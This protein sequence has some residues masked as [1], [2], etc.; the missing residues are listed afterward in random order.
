MI[1]L[2]LIFIICPLL[3][4]DRAAAQTGTY[5][6]EALN[7]EAI[8]LTDFTGVAGFRN[9]PTLKLILTNPGDQPL[10]L[11]LAAGD[12][13]TPTNQPTAENQSY[14]TI[15]L[16]GTQ[17]ID[18]NNRSQ[19][20][21]V[22]AGAVDYPVE[23]DAYCLEFFEEP[24]GRFPDENS[25]Y[26][27]PSDIQVRDSAL[28][29]ILDNRI[30]IAT[31]Q[32]D[33]D[34]PNWD[35]FSVQ[36]AIWQVANGLTFDE[37]AA[38][39]GL[40]QTEQF[41]ASVDTLI[42]GTFAPNP[43]PLPTPTT[44]SNAVAEIETVLPEETL[45]PADEGGFVLPVSDLSSIQLIV[46]SSLIG[47]FLAFA[48]FR[49]MRGQSQP[50]PRNQN[51]GRNRPREE[52]GTRRQENEERERRPEEEH[53]EKCL[54]C[55]GNHET[56]QCPYIR[57]RTTFEERRKHATI[58]PEEEIDQPPPPRPEPDHTRERNQRNQRGRP[59]N[60]SH[61]S[62]QRRQEENYRA[63]QDHQGAGHRTDPVPGDEPERERP[64]EG[65]R[66]SEPNISFT[67][68]MDGTN[69]G[70]VKGTDQFLIS[71]ADLTGNQIVVNS[72]NV[73]SPHF[74]IRFEREA[75]RVTIRDL[76]SRNGT[77]ING[78]KGELGET[79]ELQH[80]DEIVVGQGRTAKRFIFNAERRQ[81]DPADDAGQIHDLKLRDV[82][83]LTR[84]RLQTLP[85]PETFISVPHLLVRPLKENL[86]FEIRDL[87]SQNRTR[88][89][90]ANG[91]KR[92]FDTAEKV[93]NGTVNLEIGRV[94]FTIRLINPEAPEEIGGYQIKK[95]GWTHQGDMSVLY[96]IEYTD[97]LPTVVKIP[98]RSGRHPYRVC[99]TGI[100]KE[101]ELIDLL[102][103][104]P[105]LLLGK[106]SGWDPVL[107]LP[108][109]LLHKLDGINFHH[110]VRRLHRE[111]KTCSL[112]NL[113]HILKLLTNGLRYLEE[114]GWVHAD[115][116][117]E[118]IMLGRDGN[119]YI[120]DFG[121]TL[122]AGEEKPRSGNKLYSA[123]EVMRRGTQF[124]D[125]RADVY[126]VGIMTLE[127]LSGKPA[128]ELEMPINEEEL[129]QEILPERLGTRAT[130]GD[131]FTHQQALDIITEA[132]QE[133]TQMIVTATSLTPEERYGSVAELRQ[134]IDQIFEHPAVVAKMA[135]EGPADLAKL[136]ADTPMA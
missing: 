112:S 55:G 39:S 123:P 12:V 77:F 14:C 60:F 43:T 116:K 103:P 57:P 75:G 90:E 121:S 101:I 91:D 88:L 32:A 70:S 16:A 109:L 113:N 15:V 35:D 47:A 33:N 108:Y 29:P 68:E 102:Q 106:A 41:R 22:P 107:E 54:S 51:E 26:F 89:V 82:W 28:I 74:V 61:E 133:F 23:V 59:N 79:V 25:S 5:W 42:N 8:I 114:E 17:R 1:Y 73:S 52:S 120:I 94:P 10:T 64:P 49:A 7:N 128:V 105:N 40:E 72:D 135:E 98:N 21:T 45:A 58:P 99:E 2:V 38:R 53:A 48:L 13:F 96:E 50:R 46:G 37:M 76:G 95:D 27:P 131:L 24:N 125:S 6:I 129:N 119:F 126:S 3:F 66:P 81:L 67:V 132:A 87:G 100:K 18:L 134:E 117:P 65:T 36:M 127:L 130:E 111:N 34:R 122:I 136:V 104:H 9:L 63:S 97:Q 78:Q 110:V 11:S 19:S 62:A 83:V 56:S 20:F 4:S 118:N 85:I 84:Q 30:A 86:D 44:E 80:R 31:I 124:V 71:R 115:L 92:T 69:Q 93:K